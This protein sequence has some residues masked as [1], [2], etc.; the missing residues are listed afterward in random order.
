MGISQIVE[1]KT[2]QTILALAFIAVGG[3]VARDLGAETIATTSKLAFGT[4]SKMTLGLV[5]GGI[6][7]IKGVSDFSK[8]RL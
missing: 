8:L 7:L 4:A 6:L 2:S 3:Y 5:G 1:S